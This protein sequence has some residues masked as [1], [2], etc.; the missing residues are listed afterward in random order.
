MQEP[1]EEPSQRAPPVPVGL[2][3]HVDELEARGEDQMRDERPEIGLARVSVEIGCDGGI[4]GEGLIP[5]M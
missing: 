2:A 5:S 1:V 3:K 4:H